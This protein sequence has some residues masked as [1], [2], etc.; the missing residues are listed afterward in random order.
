LIALGQRD[1]VLYRTGKST[2]PSDE[3]AGFPTEIDLQAAL[4]RRPDAVVVC[5][6]TALH[7]EV[8]IPAVEA[9]CHILL[10][11]PVSNSMDRVEELQKAAARGHGRILVGFQFRFHATL[12][13]VKAMTTEGRLGRVISARA[14]WGEYLPDWHPWEDHR[15]SYA[16]RRELGGG[17]LLTLCHPLDYLGWILGEVESVSGMVGEA[18]GLE[19]EAVAEAALR[20]RSGAFGHVHLDYVQRPPEH[21][22]EL[23]GEE[24]T[25]HWDGRTGE[26]KVSTGPEW[27]WIH[28]SPPAGYE[29]NEMFMA[30]M[31]HFV[32]VVGGEAAP[33]CSLEDGIRVQRMIETIRRSALQGETRDG[34]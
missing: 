17:A 28:E 9:G 20:F 4:A 18:L 27:G 31:A 21:T 1:I 34:G 14:S 7:L 23:I 13:K 25:L 16:A 15:T 11:K 22:L 32:R 2:L 5:N 3:L 30:E 8:A 29:R 6:P 10:E 26:L 24:G 12:Q 19:V 33:A